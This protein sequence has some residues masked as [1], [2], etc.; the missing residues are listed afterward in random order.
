MNQ[1]LINNIYKE[2]L[3]Y[4]PKWHGALANHTS[5]AAVAMYTMKEWVPI[6]DSEILK[7]AKKYMLNL[8][9]IRENS[10]SIDL[11]QID[12]ALQ[13]KLLGHDEYYESWKNFFLKEFT[14]KDPKEI[15][16]LWLSRL[17]I[18]I[19]AAAGHSVIRLAYAFMAESFLE[20]NV[21][22]EEIATC[23]GDYAARYFPLST[24]ISKN[25]TPQNIQLDEFILD[26]NNLPEAKL[27]ILSSCRLIEDK[28]HIC[29]NFPEFQEAVAQVNSIIDFEAILKNLCA[30]AINTPSFALLHCITLAHA[31]L[32]LFDYLPEFNK[33]TI[34]HGYRDYVIA[35]LLTNN[36]NAQPFE[37]KDVS[38]D[39]VYQHVE[40]L[41]NDHSQKIAF[42]LMELHKRNEDPIFL[43]AALSFIK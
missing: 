32:H 14:N 28:Y 26:H 29:R 34:Y 9:P 43:Q 3:K 10:S 16:S 7:Q 30:I 15:T 5:M 35:A 1:H 40:G 27:S 25:N 22:I 24:E 2:N 42:T 37:K 17:G 21:F 6:E 33:L 11:H 41:E 20:R 13:K 31:L 8:T 18:G 4:L 39:E 19:S 23:F 36:L 12:W 38:L